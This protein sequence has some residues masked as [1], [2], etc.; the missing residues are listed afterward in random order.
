MKRFPFFIVVDD[1]GHP[2]VG[3]QGHQYEIG[4]AAYRTILRL[5]EEF[6]IRIPICFTMKYLDKK[7]ISGCAKPLD[8]VDELIG[9]LKANQKHIEVGYHGLTHEHEKHA[10]EFYCLDTGRPV[11][12]ALQE[13]HIEKSA[14][15]FSY[16]GLD[17][18]ELFV[19]PYHAWEHGVTDEL[20]SRLGVKYLVSFPKLAYGGHVYLWPPSRFLYFLYRGE[21]GLYSYHTDLNNR[22]LQTAQKL[23]LPRKLVVNLRHRRTLFNRRIHSYMVHIGNFLPQN[24]AFWM[25]LLTWAKESPRIVLCEDNRRAANFFFGREPRK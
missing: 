17:F 14:E 3:P 13:E 12:A 16:L 18:P 20:V 24:Y 22:H 25:K 21:I 9:L 11:P 7:N 8:Y 1:G 23:A 10:G 15:I 5:A 2:C 4:I 19:P 6:G